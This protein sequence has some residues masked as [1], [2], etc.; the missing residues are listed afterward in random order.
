MDERDH[1]APGIGEDAEE[2]LRRL[3]EEAGPRQG[4]PQAELASIT[5]AARAAWHRAVERRQ[6]RS[7]RRAWAVAL[8]AVLALGIGL[9]ARWGLRS[10]A[11][12]VV[13]WL[14]ATSGEVR[15][16]DSTGAPAAGGALPA[17]TVLSTGS[18]AAPEQ[19]RAALRLAQGVALRLDAG[20]RV[21]LISSRRIELERG[22]VYVDTGAG[23]T[24]RAVLVATPLGVARDI[25]TRFVVRLGGEEPGLR[26]RVR[27][28]RVALERDGETLVTGAGRELV[29]RAD[30]S[31]EEHA[32]DPYGDAWGWVLE[33]AA[34]F[35]IEGRTLG[36]LLDV[37]AREMGWA[38]RFEP[39]SLAVGSRAVVLH[40]TTGDLPLDRAI[41]ALLPGAGLRGD[42]AD[43]VLTIRANEG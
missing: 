39:P 6:G 20:T 36:E 11:A 30:G 34:P 17:G 3:L 16:G 1:R 23:G 15:L 24:R 27:E 18:A 29:V 37:A 5:A 43:R 9:A 2:Q 4:A 7:R 14:E 25:G 38:V 10:P 8:A 22:A 35:D 21:R 31:T 40:G 28:G 12:P 26:V 19:G 41:L 33:A 42:L 13:G 32:I